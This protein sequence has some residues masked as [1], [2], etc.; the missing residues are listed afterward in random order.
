MISSIKNEVQNIVQL[1]NYVLQETPLQT[2]RQQNNSL[3]SYLDEVAVVERIARS[4]LQQIEPDIDLII[5]VE[6]L[7]RHLEEADRALTSARNQNSQD[8]LQELND[9]L[10]D[11]HNLLSEYRNSVRDQGLTAERIQ[12]FSQFLADESLAGNQCGIC[13]ELIEV[14]KT[15]M[16]LD[17]NGHHVFCHDCVENWFAEHN[18]CPNCRHRF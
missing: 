8:G 12:Q 9:L 14:G 4:L 1:I 11:L 2:T 10:A 6:N 3:E 17:C 13:L 7:L 16:R 15:M 5:S 18:T